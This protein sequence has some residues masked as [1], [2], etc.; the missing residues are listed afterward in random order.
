MPRVQRI[1]GASALATAGFPKDLP[2]LR[3]YAAVKIPEFHR[4]NSAEPGT[5]SHYQRLPISKTIPLIVDNLSATFHQNQL[6]RW[7]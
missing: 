2:W 1:P 7:W 6:S 4:V 5:R 3:L